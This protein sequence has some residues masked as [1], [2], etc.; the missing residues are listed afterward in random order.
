MSNGGA[1]YFVFLRFL[2]LFG[3][4]SDSF[5]CFRSR[6]IGLASV[7]R[8]FVFLLAVEARQAWLHCAIFDLF[9]Q[10]FVVMFA[11]VG[12]WTFATAA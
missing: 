11:L 6:C 8:E 7:S 10:V 9:A 1:S 3:G 12:E 4:R 2:G 5:L